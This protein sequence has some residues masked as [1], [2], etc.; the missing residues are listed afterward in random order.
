MIAPAE[1]QDEPRRSSPLDDCTDPVWR[2]ILAGGGFLAFGPPWLRRAGGYSVGVT[3]SGAA[4]RIYDAAGDLRAGT[5]SWSA[6]EA[7]RSAL[8]AAWDAEMETA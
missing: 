8:M 1:H 2:A 4:F 6:A 3:W 5:A 7:V